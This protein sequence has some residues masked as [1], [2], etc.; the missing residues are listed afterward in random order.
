MALMC[1]DRFL[2][3]DEGVI[4]IP[5]IELSNATLPQNSKF[6]I[7]SYQ[8]KKSRGYWLRDVYDFD[9]IIVHLA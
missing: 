1:Y 5:V 9:I 8:R 7:W 4:D 2:T 3:I 6:G